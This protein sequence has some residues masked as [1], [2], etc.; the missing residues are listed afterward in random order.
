MT[1]LARIGERTRRCTATSTDELFSM[2][3][4]MRPAQQEPRVATTVD[5]ASAVPNVS[6]YTPGDTRAHRV[7]FS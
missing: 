5:P 4:D 3:A 6:R 1:T 7:A 2:L